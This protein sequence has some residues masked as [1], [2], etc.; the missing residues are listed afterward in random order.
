MKYYTHG[1][2]LKCPT[3]DN[4]SVGAKLTATEDAMNDGRDGNIRWLQKVKKTKVDAITQTE[5][6]IT[7]YYYEDLIQCHSQPRTYGYVTH[8]IC[9]V[10]RSTLRL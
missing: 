1:H 4:N 5:W 8:R 3:K 6:D 2:F 10:S 9:C 7:V